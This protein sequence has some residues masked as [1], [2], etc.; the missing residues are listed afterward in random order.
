MNKTIFISL[1]A[2]CLLSSCTVQTMCPAYQSAFVFDQKEQDGLYS[3][4]TVFE[5]D[6]VPK[7]PLGFRY[8]ADGDTLMEK[9]INGTKGRGFRVQS[10]RIHSFEK[11]GFTYENRRKEKLWAKV[12]NGREKPVLENPYL[13]DRIVKKRPFYK[14]DNLESKLIHFN[15]TEYDSLVKAILNSS[16]TT[17]HTRLMEE[18]MVLPP[19]IQV[20]YAPILRGGFNV[21]QEAYNKRFQEYFLKIEEAKIEDLSDTTGLMDF[22]YDTLATDTVAKKKGL[23]G[24][25]KKKNKPPKPK[26][27]RKKKAKDE[28]NE[29]LI[30]DE[31]TQ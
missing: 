28:N 20:Q 16:D 15:R 5:G 21:E 10:G 31:K 4:F 14:L 23:F 1:L 25:F 8:K 7:R 12:F 17:T 13:F 19:A 27:E 24:L 2:I 26:K 3:L 11:A 6:T 9:F 22:G 29:G 18:M 30:P